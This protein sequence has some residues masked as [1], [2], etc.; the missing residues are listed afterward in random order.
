MFSNEELDRQFR[1]AYCE[2]FARS[3][4]P[5]LLARRST[6]WHMPQ[7]LPILEGLKLFEKLPPYNDCD[8]PIVAALFREAEAA[9]IIDRDIAEIKL[10]REGSVA[11]YF[12]TVLRAEA[13]IIRM[14][15]LAARAD[16]VTSKFE[17]GYHLIRAWWD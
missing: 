14:I 13:F 3:S 5:A 6:L 12:Q 2:H 11:L 9:H 17:N 10:A 4:R 15:C 1:E 8:P 16:E 7:W